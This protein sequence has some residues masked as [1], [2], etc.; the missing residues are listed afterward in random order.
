MKAIWYEQLGTAPEVLRYGDIDRPQPQEGEV[1]V[2]LHASSVNP[3]DVKMRAGTRG[4]GT[5]MAFPRIIP[6]SD[7][8]GVIEAAGKGVDSKRIGE[9]VW[10]SNGQWQ[11]A[12]GTAAQYIAIDQHL[13]APLPDQV[14]FE[15]G[16]S[17]GIPALTAN[18]C[19]FSDGDIKGL[20]VLVSGGA[21]TVGNLAV[22]FA[23]QAGATVIATAGDDAGIES[24]KIAGAHHVFD[25]RDE[26]LAKKILAANQDQPVDRII[27]VEFGANIEIDAKIIAPRGTIVSYGSTIVMK[28]ELPFYS[29]MFKGVNIQLVLVYLLSKKER[30]AAVARVNKA[31]IEG[32]IDVP[33]HSSFP[34]EEC[35]KAHATV[36]NGRSGSV[37]LTIE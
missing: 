37:V 6:H 23:R 12:F 21:G 22:Q 18:H 19:L 17:L 13:A 29:L 28:P 34:L 7:G 10:I 9:R 8:A 31:L 27:E 35:A 33:I 36:E 1:L 14:P 15:I 11:R 16:A 25:Y 4:G 32:K 20:T 26:T 2:R 24:A 30:Q 3:S 5:D